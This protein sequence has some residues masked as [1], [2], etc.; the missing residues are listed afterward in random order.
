VDN[1]II[2]FCT[3]PTHEIGMKIAND[4]VSGKYAA[5]VNIIAG[6]TS[7]Y[8]WKGDICNDSELLLIIKSRKSLFDEIS[9]RIKA[10]HPYEVPEIIY[11][12]ITGGSEPYLQWLSDSTQ[13][14]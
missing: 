14:R 8:R 11:Y 13:I 6:L 7:I 3:V 5:C 2:V 9:S 4:L 12:S 1:Y 10:L